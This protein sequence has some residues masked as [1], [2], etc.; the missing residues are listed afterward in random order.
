MEL[1]VDDVIAYC[2]F[3]GGACVCLYEYCSELRGIHG[4]FVIL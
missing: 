3:R 2:F 1:H 4:W